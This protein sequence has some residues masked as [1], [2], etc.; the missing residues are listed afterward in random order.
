MPYDNDVDFGD[1]SHLMIECHGKQH[2]E[3]SQYTRLYAKRAKISEEEALLRQ[4]ERDKL[5]KEYALSIDGY[6]YLE[7]SY[8]VIKDGS[9]KTL[10]DNKIQ[11]I[12]NN[13]KLTCAS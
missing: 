7:L 13:T 3:I 6:Y 4:Q 10:I 2:Y 9:F 8:K 1:G 5:K 11:E 12:L